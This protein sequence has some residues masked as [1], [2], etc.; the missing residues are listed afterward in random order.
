M[1]Q[2]IT[3]RRHKGQPAVNGEM[4]HEWTANYTYLHNINGIRYTCQPKTHE[5]D[6]AFDK[7]KS[8][9][10][11]HCAEPVNRQS[12]KN[13]KKT[14]NF[15]ELTEQRY[16]HSCL[17]SEDRK[18]TPKR[19]KKAASNVWERQTWAENVLQVLGGGRF[20]ASQESQQVSSHNLHCEGFSK[21]HKPEI[22]ATKIDCRRG[23]NS[24]TRSSG[25]RQ[26]AR[27][28]KHLE[29]QTLL[30]TRPN[31]LASDGETLISTVQVAYP[32]PS[33][34]QNVSAILEP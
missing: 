3:C 28:K 16:T 26:R 22:E 31:L 7:C 5:T 27:E 6:L 10:T 24:S 13:G 25:E 20:V 15:F 19:R 2:V 8:L 32:L 4:L 11:C 9:K 1:K 21:K 34:G 14:T 33:D 18:T 17:L 30:Y 29:C 23:W 12:Q